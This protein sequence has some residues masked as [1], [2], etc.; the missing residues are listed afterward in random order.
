MTKAH[1][2]M[3]DVQSPDTKGGAA[4]FAKEQAKISMAVKRRIKKALE[5]NDLSEEFAFAEKRVSNLSSCFQVYAS[6]RAAKVLKEVEGV[7]RVN[8]M[9]FSAYALSVNL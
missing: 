1:L 5:K 9:I 3:I 4:A 8:Q 7:K 2:Y 6:H